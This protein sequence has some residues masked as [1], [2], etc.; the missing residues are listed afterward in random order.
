[1]NTTKKILINVPWQNKKY[2]SFDPQ[3]RVSNGCYLKAARL[4]DWLKISTFAQIINDFNFSKFDTSHRGHYLR[5]LR[6]SLTVNLEIFGSNCRHILL[7][8]YRF[9]QVFWFK[10]ET[11][12]RCHNRHLG[13]NPSFFQRILERL[14]IH[15]LNSSLRLW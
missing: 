3:I 6:F 4:W 10:F 12:N 9:Q 1:M 7:L 15:Y 11:P 5:F 8:P 14:A 2:C 13:L